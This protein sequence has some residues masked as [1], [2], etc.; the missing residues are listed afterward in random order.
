MAKP[1]SFADL[2]CIGIPCGGPA[3]TLKL[4]EEADLGAAKAGAASSSS[5]PKEAAASKA[6]ASAAPAAKAAAKGEGD[7]AKTPA[8]GKTFGFL[9]DI[10]DADLAP[11]GRCH[12]RKNMKGDVIRTR[13]PPEPN[14]YLHI[15]HAKSIT[16]NFT[17]A[18]MYGGRCHLRFDDTNPAAEETEYVESI[19]EDVRWLGFD[20]G[21]HLFFASDYFDQ[22]YEWAE[23]LIKNGKAYVDSQSPEEMKANRGSVTVLGKD[24]KFRVRTPDE[25]LKLFREMR[26]GKYKAGEHV[27]RMKGDMK[28]SNMNMRDMPIYRILHKEHHRTGKKWCIYPLYDFAHGQEDSIEGITHSICT[29]EFEAHRELY[30]WFTGNLPIESPPKQ[31]EF[32]R[33]NVT[34]FLTSKRKLLKLVQAKVVDGWDDPRMS[35]LSGLRRRGVTPEA[36]K[37][38]ILKLGVTKQIS[39]TDVALLDDCIRDNLD[40][41]VP[42]RMAVLDPLKVVIETYPEG[43]EEEVEAQNHPSNP[44]MGARKL[45]F[46]REVW[47]ERDDFRETADDNYFRLKPDGEVKLRYS[48]VIKVK[49]IVKDKAGKVTE[50]RCTHDPATRDVMPTDRKVKGVIHWVSAKHCGSHKVRL[51]E[52]LLKESVEEAA[53]V[54]EAAPAE[55]EAEED[56]GDDFLKQVNTKSL[57]ELSEAKLEEALSNVK[58]YDRFQF[59]RNGFFVCDKYST[60]GEVVFNRVIGLKESGLKKDEGVTAGRSRKEEQ[61]KQAAEKEAK[62][63]M[64]PKKMFLDQTDLYSKF[65][66]DGVPTHGADGAE[67]PKSRAKKLKQEWDKQKKLFESK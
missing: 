61:A 13:F 6:K 26:D 64:D 38:F 45:K 56:V 14:G 17:L 12:H 21:E 60:G 4:P 48:Y 52:P 32:A 35:T 62:K 49:E 7:A 37:T 46:C 54:A 19:Q 59:E 25:N 22:L 23:L 57:V 39:V 3:L 20:W 63:K 24:S 65:D 10:I 15:G 51:Y 53:A 1:I 5:K 58:P 41:Q 66:D 67:L 40:P 50:L 36:L 55:E 16:L 47:I 9:Q 8:G 28:S 34:T 27:L 29:L 44:E 43:K 30:E 2:G 42:R 31:T 18:Q 33:M 11:G